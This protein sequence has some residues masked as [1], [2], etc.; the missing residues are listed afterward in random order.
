MPHILLTKDR[1]HLVN[2][3]KW[4][5]SN[6]IHLEYCLVR[7][8]HHP[9]YDNDSNKLCISMDIQPWIYGIY[10]SIYSSPIEMIFVKPHFAT[11]EFSIKP[12]YIRR[13]PHE[14]RRSMH[15]R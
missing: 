15:I 4:I 12:D 3:T 14:L 11:A 13:L 5:D 7:L 9:K 1:W 2:N 10:R 8:N 6:H